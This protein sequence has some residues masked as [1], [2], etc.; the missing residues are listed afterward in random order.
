MGRFFVTSL[1]ARLLAKLGE[2]VSSVF[3]LSY[4]AGVLSQFWRR[5]ICTLVYSKFYN[6]HVYGNG[7]N[8]I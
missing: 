8:T 3:F 4:Y 1:L 5:Q 2:S 7:T 6:C